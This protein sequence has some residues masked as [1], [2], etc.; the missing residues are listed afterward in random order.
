[1]N[2]Y[3]YAWNDPTNW[4]DPSGQRVVARGA[5]GMDVVVMRMYP[6]LLR[7]VS[8]EAR[9]RIAQLEQSPRVYTIEFKPGYW[10]PWNLAFTGGGFEPTECGGE[11]WIDPRLPFM[12]GH[13][14]AGHGHQWETSYRFMTPEIW[15][16]RD[17]NPVIR[18]VRERDAFRM[19]GQ[20]YDQS[21]R[22]AYR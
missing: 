2:F 10:E 13:E 3:N 14:L 15:K 17:E 22:A 19:A 1:V 18:D 11:I 5:N 16:V 4:V 9:Q 8:W 21:H 20:P 12:L 6:A 7:Q